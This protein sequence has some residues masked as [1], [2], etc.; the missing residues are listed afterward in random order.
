MKYKEVFQEKR[1]GNNKRINILNIDIDVLN[2]KQ[3]VE[4]VEKYIVT[5]TPL[6]LMGVNADKINECNK[7]VRLRQIVNSCGVINATGSGHGDGLP[8]AMPI[9]TNPALRSSVTG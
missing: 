6:H 5:K 4:L 7:N 8:K 9:A 2:M 3:T 1:L